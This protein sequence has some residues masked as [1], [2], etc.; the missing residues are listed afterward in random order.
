MWGIFVAFV[1]SAMAGLASSGLVSLRGQSS[2]PAPEQSNWYQLKWVMDP[3]PLPQK[4][5]DIPAYEGPMLPLLE[6]K[7]RA[8]HEKSLAEEL[9]DD[10]AKKLHPWLGNSTRPCESQ[11][12]KPKDDSPAVVHKGGTMYLVAEPLPVVAAPQA[13]DDKNIPGIAGS[14]SDASHKIL[15]ATKKS[16]A[17]AQKISDVLRDETVS[18]SERW[19]RNAMV[20]F[21]GLKGAQGFVVQED[22]QKLPGASI[23]GSRSTIPGIPGADGS[24]PGIPGADSSIPGTP[25]VASSIP[26][27]PYYIPGAYI[28]GT[29]SIPGTYIPGTPNYSPGM[30]SSV[31]FVPCS[32]C[33]APCSACV[34]S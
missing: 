27:T 5:T 20:R 19:G 12:S 3:P 13:P 1:A 15:D 30:S 24:I 11:T 8:G 10:L 34:R 18:E 33:V 9:E 22:F 16:S 23:P 25:G 2:A 6:G 32:A 4:L 26:G 31:P 17:A 29:P 14:A 7:H 28:A 21:L